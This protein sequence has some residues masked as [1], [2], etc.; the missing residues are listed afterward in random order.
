MRRASE[1]FVPLQF[2][3]FSSRAQ[4][5]VRRVCPVRI[6]TREVIQGLDPRAS[7]QV[8]GQ[9]DRMGSRASSARVTE[10]F[11]ERERR[12]PPPAMCRHKGRPEF[13]PRGAGGERIFADTPHYGELIIYLFI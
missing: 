10:I 8:D 9:W 5:E 7:L 11:V 3:F 4:R 12:G 6:D 1:N 2:H 13:R